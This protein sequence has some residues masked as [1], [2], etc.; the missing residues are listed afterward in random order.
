MPKSALNGTEGGRGFEKKDLH[1]QTGASSVSTSV[2]YCV[3][4]AKQMLNTADVNI[5]EQ[6]SSINI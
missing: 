2:W 6:N 4:E 3:V 5:E 1:Q